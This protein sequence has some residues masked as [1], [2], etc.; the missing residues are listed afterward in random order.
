MKLLGK[1]EADDV[2]VL[3]MRG[4]Q[5]ARIRRGFSVASTSRGSASCER[6]K[7]SGSE[8]APRLRNDGRL[9]VAVMAH[10][11]AHD[12][13]QVGERLFPIDEIAGRDIAAADRLQR[14]C[15]CA[16]ACGGSSPCR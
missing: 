14:L 3:V 13:E 12:F 16:W 8:V 1:Q 10:Q 4:R 9:H 6:T 11:M 2:E 7:C 15:G 5:P